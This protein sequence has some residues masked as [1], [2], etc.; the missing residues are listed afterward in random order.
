LLTLVV[1]L[2]VV[3]SA[4]AEGGFKDTRWGFSGSLEM[5]GMRVS[6][7]G[8]DMVAQSG[9]GTI[10]GDSLVVLMSGGVNFRK[11]EAYDLA[12]TVSYLGGGAFVWDEI[13]GDPYSSFLLYGD[14]LAVQLEVQ[15]LFP[16]LSGFQP[17]LGA[18]YSLTNGLVDELKDGFV[19]GRG[20]FIVGGLY[21]LNNFGLE[22]ILPF[23]TDVNHYFG[24]R[25]SAYYRFPYAYDFRLDWDEFSTNYT[26]PADLPAMES[27]FDNTFSAGSIAIGIGLSLGYMP[28]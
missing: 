10:D 2:S 13:F 20:P 14:S 8:L 5:G 16:W 25:I 27:F 19:R 1:C 22:S 26:G 18:G 17:F 23:Y 3:V 6:G 11:L 7:E 9:H 21:I 15:P 4:G 28:F 12:L 24:I